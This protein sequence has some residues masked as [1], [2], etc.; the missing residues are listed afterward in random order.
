MD[1]QKCIGAWRE[2]ERVFDAQFVSTTVRLMKREELFNL[3]H[4]DMSVMEH[5]QKFIN[6]L[7]FTS[8]IWLSD[9][10]MSSMFEDHLNPRYKGMVRVQRVRTLRVVVDVASI[11]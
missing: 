10:I 4:G 11:T 2:F 6:L 8:G 3:E 5:E 7:A 1:E 9:E